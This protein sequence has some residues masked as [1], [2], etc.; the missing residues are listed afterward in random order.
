MR[1]AW[2]ELI[3]RP[4]R[5]VVAGGALTLIVVLVLVLGGILDALTRSSTGLFRAQSASV[6][7][8]SADSRD[9]L[10]R[11]RIPPEVRSDVAAVD[12]VHEATGL[13]VALLGARVP[14]EP[15]L[16]DV[17]VF[18]YEAANARVPPPPGDGE[19][20]ADTSLEDDGVVVGSTLSIGSSGVPV[21]VV[22]WVDDTN[23]SLQS[24]LWVEPATWRTIVNENIPNGA[25]APGTFQALVVTPE[26]VTSPRRLARAIEGAVPAVRALT[27]DEAIAAIPGV[28]E[29]RSVVNAIIGV[30]LA[31]AGLVVALFFALITI[32]RIGLLGVLKAIGASS[33]ILAAG[34][35]LQAVLV[36]VGATVIGTVVTLGLT[37]VIPE[38]VPFRLGP[39]RIAWT[40]VGVVG[41]ALIG[42]AIS[43]R[44]IIRVD[45]ASVVGGA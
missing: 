22:G 24:G 29:Q 28:T 20:F 21:H 42:S 5:F 37:S 13:G 23:Y 12:G 10:I 31:V 39:D 9:S 41:T 3:R 25:I 34:L 16:V 38:A 33:R 1:T 40:A 2:T 4:G 45:P 43:F 19:A 7:V 44:R 8:Y 27:V 26:E 15:E 30:T 36:A 11:S 14:G 32:E 6:V 18:G 17:A 35:T